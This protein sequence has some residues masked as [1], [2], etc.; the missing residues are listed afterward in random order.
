VSAVV[1]SRARIRPRR[2]QRHINACTACDGLGVWSEDEW[3]GEDSQVVVVRCGECDATGLVTDCD[4]CDEPTPLSVSET[5][6]GLCGAC[7]AAKERAS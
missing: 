4:A 3:D 5:C 2:P 1:S 6:S 7:A